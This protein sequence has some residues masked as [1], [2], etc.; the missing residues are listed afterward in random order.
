MATPQS[1]FP[2]TRPESTRDVGALLHRVSDDLKT[3]AR[4]ELELARNEIQRTSREAAVDAAV[5]LVGGFV[6]LIGLGLLCMVAVVALE[7][8]IPPLWLRL[9]IMAVVYLG[10]G[11]I[12]AGVFAKRMRSEAVPDT[13]PI[14]VHAD[15]TVQSVKHG[16]QHARR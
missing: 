13:R 15:R 11:S 4:D 2:N 1:V 5:A 12:V 8:V 9:L 6:A 16:L 7:P 3:I 10:I 14:K